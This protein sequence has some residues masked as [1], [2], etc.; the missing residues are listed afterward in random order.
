MTFP[1][2]PRGRLVGL[3]FGTMR[4]LRRGSGSHARAEGAPHGER[5]RAGRRLHE[6]R[7]QR[8]R[9]TH[10]SAPAD[11]L[12]R[13]LLELVEHRR[14]IFPGSFVFVLS[15]FVPPPPEESWLRAREHRWDVVP[16]VIQDP[17]WEQ[18]FP[19]ISGIEVPLRDPRSGRVSHVRLTARRAAALR[20]AHEERLKQMIEGFRLLD[21]DP[22]VVSSAD[23]GEI[24]AVFL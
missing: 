6:L 11:T 24:L 12:D 15:D 9:S 4:S 20:R 14:S 10:F 8:L 17:L 23:P 7:E 2:V 19:D 21:L 18:S 16:V 3:S 1:L 22:V 13:A 5:P